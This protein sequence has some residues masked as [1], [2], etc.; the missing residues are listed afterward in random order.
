MSWLSVSRVAWPCL[1]GG[2]LDGEPVPRIDPGLTR[3]R[4]PAQVGP[5]RAWTRESSATDTLEFEVAEYE[6]FRYRNAAFGRPGSPVPLTIWGLAGA[7]P[8]VVFERA[9]NTARMTSDT[10]SPQSARWRYL[11]GAYVRAMQLPVVAANWR[12]CKP[13]WPSGD[14]PGYL[15]FEDV[16][17]LDGA[18]Y[19]PDGSGWTLEGPR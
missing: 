6:L 17:R 14:L 13:M 18:T 15:T 5:L 19:L 10:F 4:L 11:T 1:V 12:A 7:D 8:A 2:R 16:V 3:L 9:W